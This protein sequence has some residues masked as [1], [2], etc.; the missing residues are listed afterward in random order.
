MGLWHLPLTDV[1]RSTCLCVCVRAARRYGKPLAGGSGRQ[2]IDMLLNMTDL[3]LTVNTTDTRGAGT[4]A[5]VYVT[6]QV[7]GCLLLLWQVTFFAAF[8]LLCVC[9]N[10][11]C[12]P[13][14]P[15]A[16]APAPHCCRATLGPWTR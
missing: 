7:R 2:K 10:L 3:E 1:P 14:G 5:D 12:S 13:A 9:G 4:D 16:A 8:A 11:W 15:E 6:I